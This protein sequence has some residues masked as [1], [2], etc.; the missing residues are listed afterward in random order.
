MLPPK[1][2]SQF[3]LSWKKNK[4]YIDLPKRFVINKKS[5]YLMIKISKSNI[6]LRRRC[7]KMLQKIEFSMQRKRHD[8]FQWCFKVINV[9]VKRGIFFCS[10]IVFIFCKPKLNNNK[11]YVLKIVVLVKTN[12]NDFVKKDSSL[13]VFEKRAVLFFKNHS[14]L[15]KFWKYRDYV[16]IRYRFQHSRIVSHRQIELE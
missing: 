5:F 7:N 14:F 4:S 3:Q 13:P 1:L 2:Q 6:Y 10:K 12:P 11:Q 15:L 8:D 9:Y 16:C